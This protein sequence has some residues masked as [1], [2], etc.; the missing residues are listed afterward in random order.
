MTG[1]APEHGFTF[2]AVIEV[3][4]MGAS[5]DGLDRVVPEILSAVGVR[6]IDGSLRTRPSSG[7]RFT[8]VTVA[9]ECPDRATY[10]RVQQDLRA[11]P[12]VRW[13]L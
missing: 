1:L 3:S 6:M 2:P 9:F 5:D 4:A 7:G 8:S 11:H 10:D 13:T 12:A